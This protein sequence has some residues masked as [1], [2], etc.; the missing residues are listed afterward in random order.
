MNTL[1]QKAERHLAKLTV[2]IKERYVGS[3]GNQLATDYFRNQLLSFGWE[4]ETH[5]FDAF[6]WIDGGASLR[7]GDMDFQ[8]FTSPYSIGCDVTGKLV[9]VSTIRELEAVEVG[10]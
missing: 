10:E 1:S 6:D 5:P 9:E 2:E 7:V 4:L 3:R 8:V